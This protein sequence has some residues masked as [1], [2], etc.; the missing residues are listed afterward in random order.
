MSEINI[1]EVWI[2][3]FSGEKVTIL[4]RVSGLVD[5]VRQNPI[6]LEEPVRYMSAFTKPEHVFLSS[7]YKSNK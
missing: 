4:G 1:G 3:R 6:K 2:N 7:Y 5:Y